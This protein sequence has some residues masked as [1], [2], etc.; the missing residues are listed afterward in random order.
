MDG[1]RAG[2]P[3]RAADCTAA[4]SG[5]GRLISPPADYRA[6]A[7]SRERLR[8]GPAS[9][10]DR[11]HAL[12]PSIPVLDDDGD[13]GEIRGKGVPP[14]EDITMVA[15]STR[16][17]RLRRPGGRRPHAG[18]L[19]LRGDKRALQRE[20]TK[21]WSAFR[22]VYVPGPPSPGYRAVCAGKWRTAFCRVARLYARAGLTK[23][24]LWDSFMLAFRR[25]RGPGGTTDRWAGGAALAGLWVARS[26]CHHD[27]SV[28]DQN[29][30]EYSTR[31]SGMSRSRQIDG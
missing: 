7:A 2:K 30:S 12:L 1:D 8:S 15:C 17:H 14:G 6:T 13:C 26:D 27:S 20:P 4:S 28:D 25:L 23:Q 11:M 29:A 9:S 22:A 10:P 18:I 3:Y 16:S 24:P 5:P 19:A 21:T 31:R